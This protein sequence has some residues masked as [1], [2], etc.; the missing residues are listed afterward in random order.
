MTDF[1]RDLATLSSAE[2]FLDYFGIAYDVEVVAV[3]R[4]HILKRFHNYLS[5]VEGIDAVDDVARRAAYRLWLDRAYVDFTQS[6]ARAEK[7]FPVFQRAA[8]RDGATF[9]PLSVLAPRTR[10]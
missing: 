6:T 8:D 4:L 7:V 5:R 10:M 1:D 2:D 3:N 9:V